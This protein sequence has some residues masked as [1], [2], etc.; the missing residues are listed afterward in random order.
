MCGSLLA[1]SLLASVVP[2]RAPPTLMTVGQAAPLFCL[3]VK[4]CVK[5][6]RR[7]EFLSTIQDNQRGTLSDE[8]LARTYVYGEDERTPNT[9]HFF[10]QYIGREGFEAH[11]AT[12][13]FAEW[14]S[15]ASSDPFSAPPIVSLYVEDSVGRA[16]LAT[17]AQDEPLFCLNV[18]LRVKPERRDDFLEALRADRA[19]AL[20]MEP[21]CATYLFGED[22]NEPNLFH[23]FEQYTGGRAGFAAH[24]QT[25]HYAKWAEFKATEPFSEGAVVSYYSTAV[26]VTS[27]DGTFGVAPK[28]FEW[29]GLY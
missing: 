22:E 1:A 5:P 7:A 10:E 17:V 27:S 11:Q 15:F 8:S 4:L 3:N 25:P 24:A 12:P 18:A 29:G 28:D 6:D 2:Y 9:F 13:H 19:G 21:S 26:P 23:M 20:S 14:E 16:G